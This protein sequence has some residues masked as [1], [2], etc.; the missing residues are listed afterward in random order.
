[1]GLAIAADLAGIV[2]LA[3][4]VV[5]DTLALGVSDGNS[6][7]VADDIAN[8]V[9]LGGAEDTTWD[10]LAPTVVPKAAE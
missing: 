5:D 2:T 6:A 1:M 8:L 9:G 10:Q 3:A 7:R 4:I